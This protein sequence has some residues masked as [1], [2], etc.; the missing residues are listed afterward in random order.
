MGEVTSVETPFRKQNVLKKMLAI[1]AKF[2]R[3]NTDKCD[4]WCQKIKLT[5]S[6]V[7]EKGLP[8]HVYYYKKLN[9]RTAGHDKTQDKYLDCFEKN[10]GTWKFDENKFYSK[11]LTPKMAMKHISQEMLDR[12]AAFCQYQPGDIY[13]KEH[14]W[15]NLKMSLPVITKQELINLGGEQNPWHVRM[16][17][18][19]LAPWLAEE[20]D[21]LKKIDNAPERA[22][23]LGY[24]FKPN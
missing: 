6:H 5:A 7:D 17:P 13:P 18:A 20:L 9:F 10:G 2:I 15:S 19:E 22:K 4:Y 8:P 11:V 3:D 1:T 21:N 12:A 24:H 14:K 16:A 23:E